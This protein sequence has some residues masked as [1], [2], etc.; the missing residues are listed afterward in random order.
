[1]KLWLLRHARVL[2]ET[3]ICYGVSDVPFD[4]LDT[5][6]AA[7]NF[8]KYPSQACAI[9][10]SPSK[11]AFQLATSLKKIRPDLQNPSVDVR[12]REMNFGEWEMR[13][14]NDIPKSEFEAWIADFSNYRFGGEESTQDVIDR[15]SD[16]MDH[17]CSKNE[18][19]LI[20]ITHA[21][22]IRAVNF[23]INTNRQ[24][25][26]S[27]AAQ[28]PTSAPSMGSWVSFDV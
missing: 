16:A 22:V 28:W 27:T 10:T 25:K 20:W 4:Q 23:L 8:S 9:W 14:W 2:V 17:A 12:L 19:E 7:E 24:Q 1:M 26:I 15:V 5:T 13:A 6:V 3:G 11:R 21:G 18:A